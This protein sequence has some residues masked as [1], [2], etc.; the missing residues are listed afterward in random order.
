MDID[1][2]ES[3]QLGRTDV[4]V[5]RLGFGCAPIGGLFRAV[6]DEA[7]A[8]VASH[9]WDI[10]IRYFDVAPLYGYGTAER[11]SGRVLAGRPRASFTPRC[12]QCQRASQ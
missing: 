6:P 9:A 1:P 12:A 2:F 11:R 7:A 5:T 4:Q 10:G 3:I 8:A